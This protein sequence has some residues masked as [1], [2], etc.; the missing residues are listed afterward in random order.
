MA[1][2]ARLKNVIMA[3]ETTRGTAPAATSFYQI[4][5]NGQI[6]LHVERVSGS[7]NVLKDSRLI[8]E[9]FITTSTVTGDLPISV[10]YTNVYFPLTLGFGLPDATVDNGDGTY[11]RTFVPKD[12]PPTISVQRL[13]SDACAGTDFY[14][15][16]T[17]VSVDGWTIN[18]QDE[19]LKA[20]MNCKG[21]KAQDS[22]DAGFTPIDTTQAKTST[23]EDIRKAHAVLSKG[24]STYNLTTAFSIQVGNA[25][26]E[27]WRIGDG[28]F[29]GDVRYGAFTMSGTLEGLFDAAFLAE[30]KNSGR[31]DFVI[32]FTSKANSSVKVEFNLANVFIKYKTQPYSVGERAALSFDWVADINSTVSATLTNTVA[33]Y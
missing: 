33:T 5:I 17:G 27:L 16:F 31:T 11:T 10:N 3:I 26:E 8:N 6:G 24:G 13:V 20:P 21:G 28:E 1:A 25:A 4:P 15:L 9:E 2:N 18:I 14:E 7:E 32:T 29:P 23:D 22:N 12:C 19:R 30:A